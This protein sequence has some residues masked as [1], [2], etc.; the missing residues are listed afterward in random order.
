YVFALNLAW[1]IVWAFVGGPNARW[2][3]LLPGGRGYLRRTKDFI[4]GY[5]RRDAPFYL[6]HDPLGRIFLTLL[7]VLLVV[8]ALTGLV[9]AGTDVYMPPFGGAMR[10][11]VAGATQDPA[12]VQPYAPDTVDAQAYADMRAFRA[13]IVDIHELNFYL[14]VVLILIHVTAAVVTEIR[15]G[16]T[17]I[18]AMFT[19]RKAHR[20]PP[21]DLER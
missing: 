12:L 15:E 4:A 5:A 14:L 18:S 17:I 1:R 10:D 7:L 8:Q 13:P 20:R 9:L 6:G 11:W 21:V 2:R 19:G 3:A 16:G